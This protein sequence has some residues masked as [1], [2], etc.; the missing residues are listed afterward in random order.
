MDGEVTLT[1]EE[2]AL[3]DLFYSDLNRFAISEVGFPPCPQGGKCECPEPK[4][5]L[6]LVDHECD[7]DPKSGCMIRIRVFEKGL[8]A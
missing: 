5:K 6:G 8:R 3:I 1:E 2:D 7:P 4:A